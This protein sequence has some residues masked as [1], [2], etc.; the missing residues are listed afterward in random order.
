MVEVYCFLMNTDTVLLENFVATTLRCN[1]LT[2]GAYK[3]VIVSF[4][5]TN[6]LETGAPARCTLSAF[7]TPALHQVYYYSSFCD[8]TIFLDGIKKS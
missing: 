1:G 5:N 8:C 3:D 2:T 6:R 7:H 4:D